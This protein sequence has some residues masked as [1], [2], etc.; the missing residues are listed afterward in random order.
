MHWTANIPDQRFSGGFEVSADLACTSCSY[1]LRGLLADGRC[2]ECGTPVRDTLL[3]SE[4]RSNLVNPLRE[5]AGAWFATMTVAAIGTLTYASCLGALLMIVLIPM[6]V[7]RV[8]TAHRVAK[9]G[10]SGVDL[11]SP[12]LQRYWL[13]LTRI[14]AW[15]GTISAISVITIRATVPPVDVRVAV[16]ALLPWWGLTLAEGLLIG[17]IGARSY[18]ALGYRWIE[19]IAA[20]T[21][22]AVPVAGLLFAL[23]AVNVASGPP[24]AW[25]LLLVPAWPL[26]VALP[27]MEMAYLAAALN[28]LSEPMDD[29]LKPARPSEQRTRTRGERDPAERPIPLDDRASDAR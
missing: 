14:G 11:G 27:A 24:G 26:A 25:L 8:F 29:I 17:L 13:M 3:R 22:F 4:D 23:L 21:V 5:H 1:N 19:V 18:K 12:D 20:I 28:W 9:M 6:M 16:F 2:P 10:F 15:V 7:T